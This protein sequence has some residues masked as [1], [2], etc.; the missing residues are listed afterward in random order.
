MKTKK[1]SFE[2]FKENQIE[3]KQLINI[4][5]SGESAHPDLSLYIEPIG[6][7]N[8]GDGSG[9]PGGGKIVLP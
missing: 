6:P 4:S 3:K 8:P 7:V 1:L 9:N 2:D 5:G